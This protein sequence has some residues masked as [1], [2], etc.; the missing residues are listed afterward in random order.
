MF[1]SDWRSNIWLQWRMCV[2]IWVDIYITYIYICP[3]LNLLPQN[4]HIDIGAPFLPGSII[5][6]Y[7]YLP[8][9]FSSTELLPALWPPTTAICGR[10]SCKVTPIAVKASCSLLTTGINCSIPWFPDILGWGWR[11]LPSY[12]C[13]FRGGAGVER[14][15]LPKRVCGAAAS[16]TTECLENRYTFWTLCASSFS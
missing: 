6:V 4:M 11:C 9:K 14:A 7:T 5:V 1:F 8:T 3:P 10:S 13:C 12:M 16:A 2:E 15:L